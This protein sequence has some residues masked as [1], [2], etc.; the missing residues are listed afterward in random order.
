MELIVVDDTEAVLVKV[1]TAFD[2]LDDTHPIFGGGIGAAALRCDRLIR[3]L[4]DKAAEPT[5]TKGCCQTSDGH[6]D[7][8]VVRVVGGRGVVFGRW[9]ALLPRKF[10]G[11]LLTVSHLLTK[12]M[13]SAHGVSIRAMR[14]IGKYFECE[15]GA[16]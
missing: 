9:R 1:N 15:A 16:P 11:Y 6:G 5:R 7:L 2:H 3:T 12:L 8:A 10:R 14:P 13:V 4:A